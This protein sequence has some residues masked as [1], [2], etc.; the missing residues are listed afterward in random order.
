MDKNEYVAMFP[1]KNSLETFA[2]I[3]EILMSIHD[4]KVKI[5]KTNLDPDA[6]EVL[7]STWVKIYGLSDVACKEDVV[8]KVATLA[9]EPVVVDELSLIETYPCF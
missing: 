1:D 8:M 5:L 9:G 4:I 3:S 2:K 6:S 7:Q